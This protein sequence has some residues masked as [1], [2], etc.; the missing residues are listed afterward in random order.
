VHD[1][2]SAGP[3]E[4]ARGVSPDDCTGSA[5]DDC[6]SNYDCAKADSRTPTDIRTASRCAASHK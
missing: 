6:T 5:G 1:G 3:N 2:C 4:C